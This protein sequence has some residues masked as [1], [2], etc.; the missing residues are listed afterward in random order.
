MSMASDFMPA[1]RQWVAN[2]MQGM[3]EFG[4]DSRKFVIFYDRTVH[5]AAR[6]A[7]VDTQGKRE[8]NQTIRAVY[9]CR[10]RDYG[11]LHER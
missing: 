1:S 4:D 11:L 6:S 3:V 5:N 8:G 2:G 10:D 9:E 7:E